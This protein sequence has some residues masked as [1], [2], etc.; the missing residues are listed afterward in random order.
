MAS[1]TA[2]PTRDLLLVV[3]AVATGATD[4]TAVQ[5]LGHVFAS[6]ITGNLVMLGVSAVAADGRLATFAGCALLGY[7]LGVLVAALAAPRGEA[8]NRVWPTGA[9]RALAAEVVVLISF[10]VVWEIVGGRPS[11]TTQIVLLAIGAGAMG[12]QSWAVRR[13]GQVSTTYLTS[14]L[15]GLLEAL[16]SRRWSAGET[17]S[18]GILAAALAGAAAGL[19][20]LLHARAWLPAL[21]LVPLAVVLVASRRLII[22]P[23]APERRTAPG[24]AE[25]LGRG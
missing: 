8:T 16:A 3:L 15:T 4:A 5:R 19:A 1:D 14:T 9:S 6:V 20:L 24:E 18:L 22:R 17:A 11:H 21:Q 23:L 10:A 12:I 25:P 2:Q 13:V 7:G